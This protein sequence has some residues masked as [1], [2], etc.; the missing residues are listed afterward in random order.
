METE[1][2]G[3]EKQGREHKKRMKKEVSMKGEWN[4]M[5]RK[6]REKK[7]REE[8]KGGKECCNWKCKIAIYRIQKEQESREQTHTDI[9]E[10]GR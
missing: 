2:R 9:E 7:G 6:K 10:R 5:G 1:K 3:E 4:N 8:K